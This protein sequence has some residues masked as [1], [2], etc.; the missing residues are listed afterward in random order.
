MGRNIVVCFDGTDNQFGKEYS[1]VIRIVQ[2]LDRDPKLQLLYYQPGIGTLPDPTFWNPWNRFKAKLGN[3]FD[4]IMAWRLEDN[5]QSAYMF[6]MDFWEPEDKVYI[7]G[8]SRGAYTARVLAGMLHAMGLILRGD[9]ELIPYAMRIY[10]SIRKS[11]YGREARQ[12][13]KDLCNKFRWTFAKE[14]GDPERRFSVHFLGLWD[15][16]S[17]AGWFWSPVAFPYTVHNPGVSYIR[18]AVSIEEKRIFFQ[19][20]LMHQEDEHQDIKQYWFSGDHSDVGGGYAESMGGL[21]RVT[22]DWMVEEARNAGLRLDDERLAQVRNLSPI[23]ADPW[24]EL[25]HN[26]LVTKGWWLAEIVKKRKFPKNAPS[27]QRLPHSRYIQHQTL[28]HPTVLQRIR[29]DKEPQYRPPNFSAQFIKKILG[30]PDCSKPLHFEWD[31]DD[32]SCT[33]IDEGV[34]EKC[35]SKL[36]SMLL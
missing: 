2:S 26:L 21:W 31:D 35:T 28:I 25:V 6:L 16:V 4:R 32:C 23:P 14:T 5:V 30:L 33:S 17:S 10:K 12:E 15:T 18:H 11:R 34:E 7:F 1:N 20:N 29:S 9:H 19:Q 13:Y 24:N 8:F 27:G 36:N 3:F 22:F